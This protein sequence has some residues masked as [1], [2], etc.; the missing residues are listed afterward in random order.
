MVRATSKE[1]DVTEALIEITVNE[2]N[3]V[4]KTDGR[5]NQSEIL[6]SNHL[7][8]LKKIQTK[9]NPQSSK[10]CLIVVKCLLTFLEFHKVSTLSKELSILHL[11]LMMEA[12]C[13]PDGWLDSY[14]D[15]YRSRKQLL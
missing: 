2:G 15:N 1:G 12:T 14:K 5:Q 3:V 10:R 11:E 9:A 6:K 7:H 13:V 8:Q 4:V